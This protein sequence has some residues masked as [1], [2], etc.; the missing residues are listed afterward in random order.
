MRWPIGTGHVAFLPKPTN[1]KKQK[2]TLNIVSKII[3]TFFGIL[4]KYNLT[5]NRYI[6]LIYRNLR[7]N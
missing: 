6:F 5:I 4:H 7:V 1:N 3:F 2:K